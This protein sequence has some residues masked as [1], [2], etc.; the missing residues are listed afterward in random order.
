MYEAGQGRRWSAK[1]GQGSLCSARGNIV[2]KICTSTPS[3]FLVPSR[4][5]ATPR[6]IIAVIYASQDAALSVS[7][8]SKLHPIIENRRASFHSSGVPNPVSYYAINGNPKF[9]ARVPSGVAAR[10]AF[11]RFGER[12]DNEGARGS[13]R[14]SRCGART[15]FWINQY[16]STAF[17]SLNSVWLHLG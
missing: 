3:T 4:P 2:I 11:R 14:F 10:A 1:R 13:W 7:T 17:G 6:G 16:I 8:A 15:T 5:R 9:R 12:S